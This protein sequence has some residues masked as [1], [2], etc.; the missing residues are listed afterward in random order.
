M[1]STPEETPLPYDAVVVDASV[2]AE[3]VPK[4][5]DTLQ[6]DKSNEEEIL[7]SSEKTS[8]YD[9]DNE[10][11]DGIGNGDDDEEHGGK[12]SAVS[13]SPT[14][15]KDVGE[16]NGPGSHR[17]SSRVWNRTV[18]CWHGCWASNPRLFSVFFRIIIP[19]SILLGSALLGGWALSRFESPAEYDQNDETMVARFLVESLD[20]NGTANL[21]TKLPL[22]C[23]D[24]FLNTTLPDGP[25][26]S[27]LV[28]FD[29]IPP[30][31]T[32]VVDESFILGGTAN[33]TLNY[34]WKLRQSMLNCTQRSRFLAD[35]VRRLADT[36][37]LAKASSDL[38]FRWGRCWNT[39][40]Y[41]PYLAWRPTEDQVDGAKSQGEFYAAMWKADQQR[42]YQQ[43]L[44]ELGDNAN[45]ADEE[46]A[47]YK[48]LDE[49]TGRGECVVNRSGSCWFFFTVMTTVGKW[50][51]SFV[52]V[53]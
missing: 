53:F 24:N 45:I 39:S 49:A 5:P 26:R 2:N 46:E 15:S 52:C 1:T 33:N 48:S 35:I 22:T 8:S 3:A 27:E 17:H 12:A 7:F 19:M 31:L 23:L 30:E 25:V 4:A 16:N 14:A 20:V 32:G 51:R 37:E 6:I 10:D 38:T 13:D 28:D 41:G 47:L 40:L 11:E 44:S 34:L 9:D 18:Q 42:L 29:G 43:Y 36:E 21:L 50:C